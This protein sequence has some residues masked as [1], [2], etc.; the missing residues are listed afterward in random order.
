MG[1][2]ILVSIRV[3]CL[4]GPLRRTGAASTDLVRLVAA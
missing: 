2:R 1:K 3:G 4:G